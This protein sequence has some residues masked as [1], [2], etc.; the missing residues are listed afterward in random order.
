M[1]KLKIYISHPIRGTSKNP[2]ME[3][4]C[5]KAILFTNNLRSY[6]P[7][8]I[9]FC[10]AE[11]GWKEIRLWKA[12]KLRIEDILWADCEQIKECDAIIS[13]CWEDELSAGMK[14]EET[15]A[16][17]NQIPIYRTRK[18]DIKLLEKFI[19]SLKGRKKCGKS[20]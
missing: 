8:I 14:F 1:K 13:Y 15:V 18:P 10:P 2:D 16:L 5:E 3:T 17:F 12:G 19:S 20:Y 11:G 9:F 7:N 4:N 6:F